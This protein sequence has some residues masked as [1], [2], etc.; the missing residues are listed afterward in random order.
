MLN[1]H[2]CSSVLGSVLGSDLGQ[3]GTFSPLEGLQRGVEQCMDLGSC[4]DDIPTMVSTTAFNILDLH[5]PAAVWVLTACHSHREP[6][7]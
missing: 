5:V 2:F 4:D 1:A 7:R 6:P 3:L